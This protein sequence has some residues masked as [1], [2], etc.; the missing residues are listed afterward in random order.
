ML[1]AFGLGAVILLAL[2]G[3][4][5]VICLFSRK[6]WRKGAAETVTLSIIP[7]KG[8]ME[9]IEYLVR[10]AQADLHWLENSRG[11]LIVLN[12][13]MDEESKKMTK[14][15]RGVELVEKEE[16]CPL[17]QNTLIGQTYGK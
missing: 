12:L 14:E 5:E 16:L 3:A 13:G 10:A 1:I 2:I 4:V 17:L 9:N 11:R 7:A 15:M 8:H 6:F